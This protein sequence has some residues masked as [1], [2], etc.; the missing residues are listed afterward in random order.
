MI[1]LVFRLD[2]DLN[3]KE[4]CL[5]LNYT[6]FLSFKKNNL[7]L[8]I[9]KEKNHRNKESLGQSIKMFP[10]QIASFMIKKSLKLCV[11]N[12]KFGYKLVSI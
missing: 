11:I 9:V 6:E 12:K 8:K 10:K 7:F 4:G 3:S 1:L 5:K 2:M